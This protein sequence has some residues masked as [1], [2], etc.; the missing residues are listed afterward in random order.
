MT[1]TRNPMRICL[2]AKAMTAHR[3][4][5]FLW[6]F[7]LVARQL[8]GM[9]HTVTV[10]TTAHPHGDPN[11]KTII[12]HEAGIEI[13]YVGNTKPEKT[14]KE[15]W[16]RSA[17]LFDELHARDPFALVMGRG[18]STW[19]Y[20]NDSRFAG[21]IPLISHEVT[22]PSWLHG[23]KINP[24]AV[25][26]IFKWTH[27]LAD[28][29]AKH[30]HTACLTKSDL[31][32]GNSRAMADSISEAFWWNAPPSRF[33][34]YAFSPETFIAKGREDL[35]PETVKTWIAEGR[36][37]LVYVG[38][39]TRNKGVFDLLHIL[40]RSSDHKLDLLI[41][42]D[43]NSTNLKRVKRQC[44]RLGISNRVHMA[45]PVPHQ[46]LPHILSK[47]KALLF[48]SVHPES[49]PKSVMEAMAAGLPI[50]GYAIPAMTELV[51]NETD[52]FLAKPD[53][54]PELASMLDRVMADEG[55]R[56]K[57]GNAARARIAAG[58][59]QD[60]VA[61]LWE[62]ALQYCVK[63]RRKAESL[64]AMITAKEPV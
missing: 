23:Y 15:Y 21:S 61:T 34:P 16:K 38:R 8:Q 44:E 5:K 51:R 17:A 12:V 46:A 35:V 7:T 50:L 49:L 24:S 33:I 1:S 22:Y 45:G 20:F 48:P 41:C 14:D 19:G 4:G 37:Y 40:K 36:K 6:P 18:H 54:W 39:V 52:G 62:E 13:H 31:V 32:I 11:G 53:N 26:D 3:G 2:F 42:G 59:T 63:T 57:L 64:P 29:T 28:A 25:S 56:Q 30:R 27:A 47:A 43:A 58:F 10:I 9:G 60:K 55:F